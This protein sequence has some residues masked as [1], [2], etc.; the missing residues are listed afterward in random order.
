MLQI[1][2]L[3]L[4][5]DKPIL[6]LKKVPVDECSPR[7]R[8]QVLLEGDRRLFVRKC[9]IGDKNPRA[10]LS[11]MRRTAFIMFFKSLPEIAS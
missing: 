9:K 3:R 7:T 2:W 1:L 11:R 6:P 5:A 4:A 8:L 10:K